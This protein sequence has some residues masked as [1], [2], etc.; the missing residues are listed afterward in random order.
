MASYKFKFAV[1]DLE[2]AAPDKESRFYTLVQMQV[3]LNQLVTNKTYIKHRVSAVGDK[4]LH[5]E[6]LVKPGE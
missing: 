3:L 4:Y 5:Y 6:I 2:L 1:V